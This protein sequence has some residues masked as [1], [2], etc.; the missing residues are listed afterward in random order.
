MDFVVSLQL[1]EGK[2]KGRKGDRSV[3]LHG[4]GHAHTPHDHVSMASFGDQARLLGAPRFL[5]GGNKRLSFGVLTI[6]D[7]GNLAARHHWERSRE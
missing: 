4:Q 1:A 7:S 2:I 5:L 3:G 6:R